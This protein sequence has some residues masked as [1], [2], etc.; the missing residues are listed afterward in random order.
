MAAYDGASQRLWDQSEATHL[1]VD[2]SDQK[3]TGATHLLGL[4]LDERA[5][6]LVAYNDTLRVQLDAGPSVRREVID[7]D[8]LLSVANQLAEPRAWPN[9]WSEAHVLAFASNP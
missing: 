1:C 7:G 2:L 3:V 4:G 9:G 8:E 6:N 5:R